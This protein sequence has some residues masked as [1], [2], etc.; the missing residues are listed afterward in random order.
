MAADPDWLRSPELK[1][2]SKGH[3]GL[4]AVVTQENYHSSIMM[5]SCLVEPSGKASCRE[6]PKPWPCKHLMLGLGEAGCLV[7]HSQL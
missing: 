6:E 4:L 2:L 7:Q 3:L 1:T 5:G